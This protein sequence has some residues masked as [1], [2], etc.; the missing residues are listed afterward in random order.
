[1]RRLVTSRP[2]LAIATAAGRVLHWAAPVWVGA[3]GAFLIVAG[4]LAAWPPLGLIA[5]GAGL[6]VADWRRT[7]DR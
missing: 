4:L 7:G 1:M 2:A 3:L 6:L 5:A